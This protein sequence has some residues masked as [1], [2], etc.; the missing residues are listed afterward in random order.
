[1]VGQHIVPERHHPL[2]D[3]LPPAQLDEF[4]GNMRSLVAR[5]KP[6]P[7]TS[8]SSSGTARRHRPHEYARVPTWPARA[9]IGQNRLE[10]AMNTYA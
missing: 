5:S 3:A 4:L 7:P 6:C 8:S 10:S 1:M 9:C 2:A